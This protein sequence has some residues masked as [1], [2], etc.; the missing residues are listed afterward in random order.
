M[1]EMIKELTQI[2]DN[3]F[4]F[5]MRYQLNHTIIEKCWVELY[6]YKMKLLSKNIENKLS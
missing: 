4:S 6:T 1:T 2:E 3:L 5:I